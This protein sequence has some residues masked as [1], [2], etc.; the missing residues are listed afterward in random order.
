M[1]R[2]LRRIRGALLMGMTWALLWMPVGLL[3]GFVV[4]PDGTMDEPWMLVGTLPGFLAGVI[5][6]VVL[7][8]SAGRH[9]L[10]ELSVATVGGWGAI[11]GL[12]IGSLPFV[13]GDLNPNVPRGLPL[14]ILG[15]ITAL[16]AV[17]AA[18]SLLLARTSERRGLAEIGAGPADFTGPDREQVRPGAAPASAADAS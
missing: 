14:V 4:D 11:A 13:I 6:S 18:G 16:S 1:A 8:I 10:D 12:V 5:F 2:W 3:I 7:G 9:R 15:S 17:S